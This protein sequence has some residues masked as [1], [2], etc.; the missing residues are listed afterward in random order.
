MDLEQAMKKI[1]ELEDA[2]KMNNADIE[3]Y[4]NTIADLN[5]KMTE[6]SELHQQE[7]SSYK[8]KIAEVQDINQKYFLRIMQDSASIRGIEVE[9]PKSNEK[10]AGGLE[11]N[12]FLNKL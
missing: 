2:I 7:I 4:K 3:N 9:E 12:D 10:Y 5:N 8:E 1:V 11:F 6:T